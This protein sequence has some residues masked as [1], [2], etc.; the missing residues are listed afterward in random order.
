MDGN[1]SLEK[2]GAVL[3]FL[4]GT[5]DEQNQEVNKEKD[6]IKSRDLRLESITIN[7]DIIASFNKLTQVL[8]LNKF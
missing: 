3:A 1:S 4:P 6:S 8:L 7:Y 5:L 2:P